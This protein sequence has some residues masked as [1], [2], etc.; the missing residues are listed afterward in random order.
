[1]KGIYRIYHTED[2][3]QRMAPGADQASEGNTLWLWEQGSTAPADCE[4]FYFEQ[5]EDGSYYWYNKQDAELVMQADTSVVSLQRKNAASANQ[6]WTIEKVAGTEDQ[7]Y[8]KNGSRY[9][10]TSANRHA[11]VSMSD[12]AQAW[13]LAKVEPEVKLSLGSSTI[14]TGE[15]TTA[16]VTGFDADGEELDGSKAVITSENPDI[17]EVSGNTVIAKKVG[18]ATIKATFEGADHTSDFH[19][20]D[21]I[22]GEHE[23][24]QNPCRHLD[25]VSG[26]CISG[27]CEHHHRNC[28]CGNRSALLFLLFS[29]DCHEK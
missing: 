1:M 7:Y 17:A 25:A 20:G 2:A 21:Q 22:G 5:A 18:T 26:A 14:R 11:Q 9:A 24:I 12:T 4:M 10:S 13:R 8:L 16:A 3:T 23:K 29:F 19:S 28:S 15:S 6:K 27:K